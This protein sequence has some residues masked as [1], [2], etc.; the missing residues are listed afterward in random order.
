MDKTIEEY[1]ERGNLIHTIFD[2][3][4]E[5][6][7]EY[8]ENNNL[9]NYKDNRNYEYWYKYDE[10]NNLVHYKTSYGFEIWY[11]YVGKV[12]IPITYQE[13]K[14]IER[15]KLLLNIKRSNRFELIDV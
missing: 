8:D 12:K 2:N 5:V 14:Q 10:N 9:I 7:Q 13:F 1:D 4:Y 3:S 6:W 11:K 15:R